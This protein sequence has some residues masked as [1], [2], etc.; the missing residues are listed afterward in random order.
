MDEKYKI[1]VVLPVYNGEKYLVRLFDSLLNQ[2]YHNF[3]IVCV[4]DKSTDSTLNILQNYQKKD[5]R[6]RVYDRTEKGGTAAKGHEYA[7]QFLTGDFFF[8]IT[9]DDYIDYDYF[10]KMVEKYEKTKAEIV[11]SNLVLC[12]SYGNVKTFNKYPLNNDYDFIASSHEMF[13]DTYFWHHHCIGI[14]KLDLVKKYGIQADYYN[15]CEYYRRIEILHC[16]KVAFADTN[17]YYENGNINAITKKLRYFHVDILITQ[18][19]LCNELFKYNYTKHEKKSAKKY[20]IKKRNLWI[21]SVY[22]V[23]IFKK[24]FNKNERLYIKNAIKKTNKII[25]SLII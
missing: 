18:A 6:I 23:E 1:S 2:T 5:N 3:E 7:L 10:S 14:Y 4:N 8:A 12:Y 24:R 16:N 21:R 17:Y 15:S 11:L 13:Y 22:F 20:L 19:M 25:N 9:H